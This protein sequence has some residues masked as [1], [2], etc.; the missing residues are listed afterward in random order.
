MNRAKTSTDDILGPNPTYFD[1]QAYW[2]HTKHIGGA[3]ATDELAALCHV[4]PDSLVLMVGCGAGWSS[5]YLV[6]T[7]GCRLVGMDALPGMVVWSRLRAREASLGARMAFQVGDACHLPY[8]EG[9]FDAVLCESVNAFIDDPA[10]A[11]SEYVRV[12]QPG[13]Y[14]GMNEAIWLERP[15]GLPHMDAYM[16]DISG[17]RIYGSEYWEELLVHA[18]LVD[19]VAR[20]SLIDLRRDSRSQMRLIDWRAFLSVVRRMLRLYARDRAVRRFIRSALNV[21]RGTIRSMGYGLYA[22]KKGARPS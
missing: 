18:G 20:P 22:G 16:E 2:G 11:V 21:P 3:D 13:G 9:I 6:Q 12:L 1:F 10:V 5:I 8:G 14:L 4:G 15:P 19:I 17:A 7:T